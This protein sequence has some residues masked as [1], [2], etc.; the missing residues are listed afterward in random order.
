[1]LKQTNTHTHTHTKGIIEGAAHGKGRGREVIAV[2]RSADLVLMVLDGG[3]EQ[4]NNHRTILE[5]YVCLCVCNQIMSTHSYPLS[6]SVP[7]R[8][9][10]YACV[11]V[12]ACI[13][14]YVCVYVCVCVCVCACLTYTQ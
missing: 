14:V 10:V 11:H 12:C 3:K 2:A 8:A 5:R 9:C 13:C 1:M 4:V 6:L 7:T